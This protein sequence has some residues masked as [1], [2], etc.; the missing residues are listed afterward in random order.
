MRFLLRISLIL[1]L[2]VSSLA[3]ASGVHNIESGKIDGALYDIAVPSEWNGK[4]LLF[5]HGLIFE[6]LPL[7]TYLEAER[8]PYKT[9][10]EE[11]WLV[12]ASSYRRNGIIVGDAMED[13]LKL[14]DF[15]VQKYGKPKRILLLGESMGGAVTL[16]MLEQY[17]SRFNGGLILGRGLMIEDPASPYSYSYRP[18][19][20][21][22]FMSN[23][24]EIEP[25]HKYAAKAG[26]HGEAVAVWNIA[27][28]GHINFNREEFI[29]AV[30]GLDR[31]VETGEPLQTQDATIASAQEVSTARF[32]DGGVYTEV[33]AVDPAFGNLTVA[34][35]EADFARLGV[36]LGQKFIIK[37]G[38]KE[39]SATH[40]K[41]FSD[42]P[43]GEWLAF[44][45]AEGHY[46]VAIN[47]GSAG[48]VSGLKP[49]DTIFLKR[50]E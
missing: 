3:R 7:S 30:K 28:D 1:L 23:Q 5:N 22:L 6:D 47:F 9:L 14:Y 39:Y 32:A 50:K 11:G 10:L 38:N 48:N 36:A 12:A 18:G 29:A 13:S 41:T 16:R 19:V 25:A 31:W 17:P 35:V 43:K 46:V 20:P 44:R 37:A 42:V 49:G 4:L 8:E 26:S 45:N 33:I 2:S 21:V 34:L 15:V 27:R 40:V 24:S